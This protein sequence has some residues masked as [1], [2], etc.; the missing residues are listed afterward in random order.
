MQ[1][2]QL[3]QLQV[4]ALGLGCMGMSEFYGT[5][6]EA[7][8]IATIHRAIELGVTFLDTADMYGV[9]R[10]EELV[11][12]A[13]ADR[14]DKVVLATKFGNVR[15]PNG[16]R[17]GISGKPDYVRQACEASLKRLKIDVIDLYY[18]HR[19]DPE[20]PIEDTVGA[21][22]DLVRQGKVRYLGLSEAGPQT[23][24]RAHAVHP[25]AALQTE[26][27]LWSRDPEDEI[28][29]T[30][31]ELG[32]GFVPYSPLGRG[33]LTGQIKSVDDLAEDDFRRN[34]PR[35]Q[36]ENF[37]KNLDLVREIEA[38]A[39]EKGC[40]PSQLALAW[41]MAQG[42]DI[43]PIPGTKRRRYLEE[44]VGALD[45]TLTD[46]DLARI[47]RIIPPGAAAGTR[48]PEPGMKMVGL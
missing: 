19:V 3:G 14:R 15:G 44:N 37:Q 43:V 25:I 40:A 7:E 45:V 34:S 24:R 48:Y 30:V 10:N 8:S 32:I 27:S 33:F 4:S 47:D 17:L 26:Y 16:E 9:G 36:S 13:I 11:G 31:R 6:D 39:R 42:N 2:R 46:E 12:R 23:M 1:Q 22:A 20:T 29:P 28:L 35:F 21:M 38:M 5:G 18:Q 41:V